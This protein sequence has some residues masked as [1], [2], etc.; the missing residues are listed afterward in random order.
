MDPQATL[1]DLM[2][3]IHRNDREAVDELLEAL[4]EWNKKG[5]FLPEIQTVYRGWAIY[6]EVEPKEEIDIY[7]DN[8]KRWDGD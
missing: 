8:H 6:R 7:A 5:G 1:Y 4:K 3:A 2:D